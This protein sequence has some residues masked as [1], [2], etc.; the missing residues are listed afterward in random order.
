MGL[1]TLAA[2]QRARPGFARPLKGV[3]LGRFSVNCWHVYP[4]LNFA[5]DPGG[6]YFFPNRVQ[7]DADAWRL[8]V[9]P[10]PDLVGGGI[11][12][13]PVAVEPQGKR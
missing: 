1:P 13:L 4:A 3:P 10:L 12:Y 6:L 9:P 7:L 8:L 11:C 2:N 5:A